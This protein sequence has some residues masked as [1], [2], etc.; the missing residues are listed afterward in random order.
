MHTTYFIGYAVVVYSLNVVL[1]VLRL[2]LYRYLF[3]YK[4]IYFDTRFT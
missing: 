1:S 4:L 3:K 2:D